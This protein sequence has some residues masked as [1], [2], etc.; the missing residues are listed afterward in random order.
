[1]C[2]PA[3]WRGLAVILLLLLPVLLLKVLV[4]R[5]ALVEAAMEELSEAHVDCCLEVQRML[6]LHNDYLANPDAPDMCYLCREEG[7]FAALHI[8]NGYGIA[9]K[10]SSNTIM[11]NIKIDYSKWRSGSVEGP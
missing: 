4:C 2:T 7:N 3:C 1:M 5:L 9:C 8:P 6:Q 11:L 10:L